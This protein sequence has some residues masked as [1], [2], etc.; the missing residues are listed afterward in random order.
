MSVHY[1]QVIGREVL[2]AVVS[3]LDLADRS[4]SFDYEIVLDCLA[5]G[6]LEGDLLLGGNG[7]L[8][9]LEHEPVGSLQRQVGG[10]LRWNVAAA[11]GE[12]EHKQE[13]NREQPSEW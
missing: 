8:C 3:V 5:G 6:Q 2:V 9:R 12:H 1:G 11:T 4:R 13:S 7:E 10:R